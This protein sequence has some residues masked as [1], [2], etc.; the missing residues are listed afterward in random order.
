VHISAGESDGR[1]LPSGAQLRAPRAAHLTPFT[2]KGV[3]QLAFMNSIS[4]LYNLF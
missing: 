3:F 2:P 4:T 1:A